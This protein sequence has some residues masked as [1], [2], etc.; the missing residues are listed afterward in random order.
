MR[1]GY[2]FKEIQKLNIAEKTKEQSANLGI[3]Y[4]TI[5]DKS[6]PNALKEIP[7][8]P[9]VLYYRGEIGILNT[10]KNIAVI[11]SRNCS[12][13]GRELAYKTGRLLAAEGMV[14]VNGLALGCDTEALRGAL[15]VL[16]KCV[17]I[18]PCGLENIQPKSN[19][20]LAQKI[21]DAGGC[22]LSEY[23][24]GTSLAKYQYVERD[25][26]QSGVSQG[27]VIIE[28]E[29]QSGTMH[30]AEFAASQCRRLACYYHKLLEMSSGNQYLTDSGRA[31]SIR[32]EEEALAFA[33]EL[34]RA[35]IYQQMSLF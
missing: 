2:S 20:G 18:M 22:I 32:N 24:V 17:A 33:K 14:V 21:I 10:Y 26:L 30:T 25:R 34:P 19:R 5:E 29:K 4:C 27:I 6:Y 23:S 15:D 1:N 35:E 11:G 13:K 28:A 31:V 9:V 3:S 8:R 7:G 12:F 16:G